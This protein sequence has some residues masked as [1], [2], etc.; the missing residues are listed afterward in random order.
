M[1]TDV[2][3]MAKIKID[4]IDFSD[5]WVPCAGEDEL[6]VGDIIKWNEP[7]WSPQKKKRG[8]PDSI[9]QQVVVAEILSFADNLY[10]FVHEN[11]QTEE[12]IRGQAREL[13]VKPGTKIT[14]K[15]DSVFNRGDCHR[16]LWKDEDTRDFHMET[17]KG[18]K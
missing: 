15:A 2:S 7:I 9:G 8:K 13:G 5:D 6:M 12:T 16:L 18:K 4:S 1:G 14:R 10:L 17:L 3:I 11:E